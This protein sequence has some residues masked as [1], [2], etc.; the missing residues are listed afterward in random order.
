[1][2]HE[3]AN[4]RFSGESASPGHAM[5][6]FVRLGFANAGQRRPGHDEA[7]TLSAALESAARDLSALSARIGADAEC[8]EFQLA[9]IDDEALIGRAFERLADGVAAD[10]AWRR[11][12]EDLISEYGANPSD[13]IRARCLDV[14][15]LRDRVLNLINGTVSGC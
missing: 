5:G 3:C 2:A 12:M 14:A 8:L 7:G 11:A 15:D 13:Y 4:N 9:L 1:M 6:P 10:V